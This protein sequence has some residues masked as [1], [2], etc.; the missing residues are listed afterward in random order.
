MNPEIITM[1]GKTLVELG[2]G[3]GGGLSYLIE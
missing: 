3:H 2:C 1:D